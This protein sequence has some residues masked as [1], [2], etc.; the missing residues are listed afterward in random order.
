GRDSTGRARGRRA[1]RASIEGS[2]RAREISSRDG[3]ATVA[4]EPAHRDRRE[5]K[6]GRKGDE[7]VTGAGYGVQGTNQNGTPIIVGVPFTLWYRTSYPVPCTLTCSRPRT[8]RKSEP[9][10][11]RKLPYEVGMP[12][13]VSR[14]TASAA[15]LVAV[16]LPLAAQRGGGQQGPDNRPEV[17]F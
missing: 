16:A 9:P 3:A 2:R 8:W 10:T 14:V 4:S 12:L 1:H 5:G 7:D 17:Q 13:L 15:L 11:A 6:R